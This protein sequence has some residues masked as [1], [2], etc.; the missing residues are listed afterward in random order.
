[1]YSIC[2]SCV[3]HRSGCFTFRPGI[4]S[5]LLDVFQLIPRLSRSLRLRHGDC[6]F[7]RPAAEEGPLQSVHLLW[8]GWVLGGEKHQKTHIIII[9]ILILILIPILILIVI[10]VIIVILI[11][12][13]IIIIIIIIIISIS[14]C[15]TCLGKGRNISKLSIAAQLS[16]W[17]GFGRLTY[18]SHLISFI[19]GSLVRKRPSSGPLSW[20]AFTPSC[21]PPHHDMSASH[22]QAVVKCN[23]SEA[24]EL[25]GEDTLGRETLRFFG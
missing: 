14:F 4:G 2:F 22:R 18:V 6:T 9:I 13:V 7:V 11:L 8:C 15:Q 24:C 3:W 16:L 20:S 5:V 12:I 1:M 25:T 19:K 21:Q 17:V 10:I 23:N